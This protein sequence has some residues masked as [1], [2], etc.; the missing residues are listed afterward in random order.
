MS[1]KIR[2]LNV[3]VRDAHLNERFRQVFA[4]ILLLLLRLLGIGV[5]TLILM[6]FFKAK[7]GNCPWLITG[8]KSMQPGTP[9]SLLGPLSPLCE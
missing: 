6:N 3:A 9:E 5:I 2:E 1:K 4:D 8:P 7:P